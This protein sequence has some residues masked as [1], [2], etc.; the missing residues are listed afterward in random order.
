M[1]V[2]SLVVC[3]FTDKEVEFEIPK[4]FQGAQCLIANYEN[5]YDSEK[6]VLKPYEAFVLRVG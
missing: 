2:I 4:E 3:S 5:S 1:E 6:M